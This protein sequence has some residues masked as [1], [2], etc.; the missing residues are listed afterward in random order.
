MARSGAVGAVA[1]LVMAVGCAGQQKAATASPAHA[2]VAAVKA[3]PATPEPKPE[4]K[5]LATKELATKE[6][7]TKELATKEL[8]TTVTL[9]EARRYVDPDL[10]FEIARP[11][12]D[13]LL[14]ANGERSPEGL[15]IPV[16]LRHKDGAQ[17]VLQVAPAVATPTQFA[18]TM[19]SKLRTHPGVTTTEPEPLSMAEGAVGFSFALGDRVSGRMAI[20]EGS[21]GQVFMMMATWP[22]GSP[23]AVSAGVEAIFGSIK[24]LPQT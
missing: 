18:E 10:G 8:A 12:G 3:A 5:A 1:V 6:L 14:E 15:S 21:K 20:F 19:T 22:S 23:E 11:A 9:G 2:E 4:P 24:A 13:W 7:A 17:V 16:V